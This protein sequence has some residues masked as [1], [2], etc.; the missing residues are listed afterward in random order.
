MTRNANGKR[1]GAVSIGGGIKIGHGSAS[2]IYIKP[3]APKNANTRLIRLNDGDSIA[4]IE[5]PDTSTVWEIA[6]DK[7]S[8]YAHPTQEPAALAA[9]AIRNHTLTGD[10]VL[11]L[12]GGSG[13]T[14]M[15][16]EQQDRKA[17]TLE[18][19]EKFVDVIIQRYAAYRLKTRK[20]LRILKNGKDVTKQ[21]AALIPEEAQKPAKDEH[22]AE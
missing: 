22:D 13:S 5:N 1:S 8:D 3:Q 15:A 21:I 6:R 20:P 16:A 14:L 12:F 9:R 7:A 18:Y 17:F 2:L 10:A 19:D 4:L 11:D